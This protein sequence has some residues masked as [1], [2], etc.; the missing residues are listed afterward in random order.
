MKP[1]LLFIL[2]VILRL[3]MGLISF[4]FFFKFTDKGSEFY[5]LNMLSLLVFVFFSCVAENVLES[6][7][8]FLTK[9]IMKEF[10]IV[11]LTS[12]L[13]LIFYY[14]VLITKNKHDGKLD[15]FLFVS[16]LMLIG[17]GLRLLLRKFW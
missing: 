2:D 7:I 6:I 4:P 1:I 14:Y 15:E 5:G 11:L 13:T 10:L 3:L 12:F 9:S 8:Y 17:M 16:F